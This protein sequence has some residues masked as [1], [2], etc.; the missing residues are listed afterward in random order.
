MRARRMATSTSTEDT[1]FSDP[2]RQVLRRLGWRIPPLE[3]D[4]KAEAG[5]D[6]VKDDAAASLALANVDISLGFEAFQTTLTRLTQDDKGA[7]II[8]TNAIYHEEFDSKPALK[9]AE[10][11]ARLHALQTN[12]RY[13][14]VARGLRLRPKSQNKRDGSLL[15]PS[16][17]AKDVYYDNNA[18]RPRLAQTAANNQ[19]A[20]GDDSIKEESPV[21]PPRLTTTPRERR[22]STVVGREKSDTSEDSGDWQPKPVTPPT[23]TKDIQTTALILKRIKKHLDEARY[24]DTI[25]T[26]LNTHAFNI[27]NGLRVG[28]T[29][30]E[31]C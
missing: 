18:P 23:T 28:P 21:P 6:W 27:A 26:T 10:V 14:L 31:E 16:A 4:T 7:A 24:I 11:F 29:D 30:E 9:G 2:Q 22:L 15:L 12:N 17:H 19:A 3:F 5:F 8:L 13:P 1:L 25:S 20:I